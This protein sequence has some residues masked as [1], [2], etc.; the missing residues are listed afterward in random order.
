M[1]DYE[2]E[3]ASLVEAIINYGREKEG[4]NGT[5]TSIFG[6]Q[7]TVNEL[8][9]GRFPLLNGRKIHYKPVLG[10]LA[11]FFN[12]PTCLEDFE[13]Q[14]CNYWSKW[15]DKDGHLF[16]DYGNAWKGID[17][18]DFI[19]TGIDQIDAVIQNIKLAPN[20]R[21]HIVNGWR[22]NNVW[23]DELSLPCCH[24][25]YQWYVDG[26]HLDMIWI[27]RSVDTM[28][29]LPSD[30]VLAAAW[31]IIMAQLTGYKP[32]SLIFQLGDTHIYSEHLSGTMQYIDQWSRVQHMQCPTYTYWDV[33]SYDKFTSKNIEIPMYAPSKHIDFL[34]KT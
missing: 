21:R 14:G 19:K 25:S 32:G 34:L 33:D 16:L 27:Q 12:G 4:R 31:N 26:E 9:E 18:N 24:Y 20:D 15:A 1:S 11:A 2:T 8:R 7:L 17:T 13:K 5:T 10:E 28:I 22:P 6:A 29:G 3:Y 30:V 23:Y